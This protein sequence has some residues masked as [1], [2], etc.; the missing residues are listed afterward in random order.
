MSTIPMGDV[1]WWHATKRG[2]RTAVVHGDDR[3][4]WP[5]LARRA[6]QRGRSIAKF[7]V[8]PGD[9][10]MIA[11][12]NGNAFV[13]TVF[14]IWMAGGIPA[15]VAPHMPLLELK[16]IVELARPRLLVGGDPEILKGWNVLPFEW[17]G[18]GESDEKISSVVAPYWKAIPS[19]GSTGTPKLI[20][21]HRPS[22]V[23]PEKYEVWDPSVHADRLGRPGGVL[24]NP[25]PLY[26]NG[27]FN[28]AFNN[29]FAGST[30]VGLLRF[31]AEDTLRQIAR[32]RVEL[33]YMVPTMM[34]RIWNLP[35]SVRGRYDLSSLRGVIH[36]AAPC[37]PWLKRAW[38]DWLG[39]ERLFECYGA[40]E[41]QASTLITGPQWL[42]HP[43]S[44]GRFWGYLS[45][46]QVKV[47]NGDG[48]EVPTGEVGELYFMP[49]AGPGSTYHYIGATP[50]SRNGWESVGDLGW[51]DA[52][53]YL[54]LADR[55][56]DLI[57]R[58]GSNVY[59]AEVEAAIEAHPD[60]ECAVV[61]GLPD[62]DLGARVHALVQPRAY[63]KG[64]LKADGL[65]EFLRERLVSY[66]IPATFEFADSDLRNEAGKVR[67]SALRAERLGSGDSS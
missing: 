21:S 6:T 3:L 17:T 23:D 2:N 35:D 24:L 66:K 28:L 33:V 15:P 42:E 56:T 34:N 52:D 64:R 9:I 11:L 13:E 20:V 49:A 1:P 36:M 27:P 48:V 62:A 41:A 54:Y 32:H 10:V 45:N 29:M 18:A 40:T 38:I 8:Q 30:L 25:G 7:G 16:Q 19:G 46:A 53:G 61:F 51:L 4:D 43:G 31:D 65:R 44:V 12:P 63:A 39:A 58:G 60:V 50:R 57:L 55:Q 14:G 37:P 22:Q 59:P 47:L 26:H 5:A 67:R